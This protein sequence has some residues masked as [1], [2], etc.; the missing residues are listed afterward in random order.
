MGDGTVDRRRFIGLGLAAAGS[1]AVVGPGPW[2]DRARLRWSSESGFPGRPNQLTLEAPD[3][4]EGAEVSIT[5]E[6]AVP[7]TEAPRV[8]LTSVQVRVAEGRAQCELPMTYPYARR[9][10]GRYAYHAVARWRGAQVLT[11]A[12]A[13]YDLIHWLPLS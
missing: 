13:T 3:L 9:V 1:A 6:V 4:P 12:P 5:L 7:D 8:A 11:E 2:V 10:P